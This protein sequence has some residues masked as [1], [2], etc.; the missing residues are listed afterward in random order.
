M[1]SSRE[2]AVVMV[3]VRGCA[4]MTS[5][6]SKPFV[7]RDRHLA[8]LVIHGAEKRHGAG[9]DAELVHQ[10]LG[11]A[12][13]EAPRRAE[14]LV[15]ALQIDIRVLATGDEEETALL[16]LEEQIL[17]VAARQFAAQ[18]ARLGHGE[19]RRMLDRARRDAETLE[20]GKELLGER[21]ALRSRILIFVAIR[22]AD[23]GSISL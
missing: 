4:L 10:L 1:R 16:V 9:F 15:Q 3:L 13:G 23:N 18:L 5:N 2:S 6:S 11:A 20:M 21:G 22:P 8:F 19:E 7:D 14:P 17:R 12:E